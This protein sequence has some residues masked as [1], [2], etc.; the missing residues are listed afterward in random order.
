MSARGKFIIKKRGYDK[1]AVDAYIEKIEQQLQFNEAKLD[2][3]RK[4][5]D[6][7]SAQLEIK[8]DQ[9]LELVNELKLLQ[10]STKRMILPE[11]ISKYMSLDEKVEAQQTADDIILEA[12]MIAKDILENVSDTALNT[13][14]YKQELLEHLF[15]IT[16]SVIDIEIIEPL[17][18]EWM[19][20]D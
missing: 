13:K 15:S 3:Y 11:E 17:V 5:L 10:N 6:F 19:E 16:N 2:V 20:E 1:L 4:Q 18:V 12:L 9:C 7:L 8:Q 14:E